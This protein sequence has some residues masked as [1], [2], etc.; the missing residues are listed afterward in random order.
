MG[1]SKLRVLR[2]GSTLLC[3]GGCQLAGTWYGARGAGI[4]KP[5]I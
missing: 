1:D 4:A 3:V 2:G 5:L